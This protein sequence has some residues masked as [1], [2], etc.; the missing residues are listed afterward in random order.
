MLPVHMPDWPHAVLIRTVWERAGDLIRLVRAAV[1][2]DLRGVHR[3][4]PQFEPYLRVAFPTGPSNSDEIAAEQRVFARAVADRDKLWDGTYHGVGE[5]LAAAG[6]PT[7]RDQWHQ[8]AALPTGQPATS[9]CGWWLSRAV[10]RC[11]VTPGCTW[12]SHA[13]TPT[14]FPI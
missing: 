4:T 1:A 9:P 13:R 10:P 3:P 11:A 6:L 8:L 2:V 7:T 12:T 14:C 5:V